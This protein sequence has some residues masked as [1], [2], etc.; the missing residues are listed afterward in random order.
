MLRWLIYG[1]LISNLLSSGMFIPSILSYHA[2]T[3][4]TNIYHP[5][6]CTSHTTLII[7]HHSHNILHHYLQ[8]NTLH[9]TPITHHTTPNTQHPTPIT[10][11]PSPITHHTSSIIY[12]LS[13]IT[14]HPSPITHHLRMDA[15]G[16]TIPHHS[17]ATT[18][19][20]PHDS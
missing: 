17:L 3:T 14:H 13:P 20:I 15:S 10:H 12:H 4:L 9:A 18:H 19:A 8:R 1:K 2:Y 11:H 16:N 5:S 6:Y 7:Q